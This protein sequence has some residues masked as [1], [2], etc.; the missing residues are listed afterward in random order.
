MPALNF[1]AAAQTTSS[2][3]DIPF[4]LG[5]STAAI[6]FLGGLPLALNLLNGATQESLESKMQPAET[7]EPVSKTLLVRDVVGFT[8]DLSSR[9]S[10]PS[11]RSGMRCV[12]TE[13]SSQGSKKPQSLRYSSYQAAAAWTVNNAINRVSPNNG[14]VSIQLFTICPNLKADGFESC[15]VSVTRT[16]LPSAKQ[17]NGKMIDDP[18]RRAVVVEYSG[19]SLKSPASNP[20]PPPKPTL[21]RNLPTILTQ[22]PTPAP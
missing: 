10:P 15:R 9:F 12:T 3:I 7:A 13:I 14:P 4:L 16:L 21:P 6:V 20:A 2:H 22:R 11:D 17:I 8:Q 19:P 1:K 18:S 5:V